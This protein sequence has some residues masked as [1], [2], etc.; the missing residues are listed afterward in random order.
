MIPWLLL[1]EMSVDAQPPAGL[2]A[3]LA[4]GA[5]IFSYILLIGAVAALLAL[6]G[7]R[8]RTSK[9]AAA[10]FTEHDYQQKRGD[11]A[12]HP[13]LARVAQVEQEIVRIDK[14]GD[15]DV[16]INKKGDDEDASLHK[17]ITDLGREFSKFDGRITEGMEHLQN[18]TKKF[19][20]KFDKAMRK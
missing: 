20:D 18:W 1:A 9:L 5:Y 2:D 19:E 6:I 8:L 17:R 13:I 12:R 3:L 11:E 14:K 16:R 4:L 10:I 7:S 15:D